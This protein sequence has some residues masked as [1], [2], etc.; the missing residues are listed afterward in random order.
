MS[1]ILTIERAGLMMTVQDAGR[2]GLLRYGVS[3][4]GAMDGEAYAIANALVGNA[5]GAA[6]VEFAMVGGA[7]RAS[8][9]CLVAVTGGASDLRIDTQAVPGWESHL[10]K[11]G[12]LL[13]IGAM[14]GAV[15]GY[16]GVSGG[17]VTPPVLGSRATHL[18]TA[19]GGLEGR[20]L[21]AGDSLPLGQEQ[22]ASRL[23]LGMLFRRKPGPVR[24]VPGPQGDYFG[25]DAWETFLCCPFTISTMR[26]R[27]ALMLDGPSL[28]AAGGHDIVSDGTLAGS[29]Q[30][31]SSG[32]PIVLMADRQTT[33]GYPKIATIASADLNRLTQMPSGGQIR[34][35]RVS[36]DEAEEADIAARRRLETV[37]ATL[38]YVDT[39]GGTP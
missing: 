17:I 37:L 19:L 22:D 12:E 9:D 16:L 7:V 14:R 29:I 23:R 18:R 31:P 25:R 8:R 11:A 6:V 35:R 10:L 21:A 32:R 2:T 5:P 20:A 1:G 24:I 34:F 38:E 4:S 39:G 27:M 36:Q 13:T 33:G 26:D 3:A 15:W 30:V 28:C